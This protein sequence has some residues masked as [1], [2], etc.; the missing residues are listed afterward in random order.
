MNNYDSFAAVYDLF[1]DDFAD[2]VEMYLGFARRTGG[3]ILE[4]GSGTG[5]VTLALA[6]AGHTVVGLEL[7]DEM[8]AIAQEK[9]EEAGQ[10]D[11]VR[12]VAG[13]MR[14]FKLDQHFGLVIAPI[15]TFLHNLTLDDQ[16]ATLNSIKKHLRPG[17]LL[18]LDCYNPD[19][20]HADDD[21]RLILQRMADDPES[22][23]LAQLWLSRTT[24][25]SQQ[26]QSITYFADRIDRRG[27]LWRTTL[28]TQFRF[29]FRYEMHLLLKQGGFDVKDIYGSYELEPFENGSDKLIAVAMPA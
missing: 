29:I 17:G 13:D 1:Y 7:S 16:L 6:E 3:P 5:R 2:D 4:I 28:Q 21:H 14:R 25:W 18:V 22:N 15:N 23:E 24:D 9:I 27:Q 19:P 20:T 10:A 8:R 12:W 26:L 11:R